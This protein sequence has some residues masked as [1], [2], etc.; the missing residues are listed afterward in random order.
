MKG[1]FEHLNL[2]VRRK[3]AESFTQTDGGDTAIRIKG[4]TDVKLSG[5]NIEGRVTRV[6]LNDTTW[7]ALERSGSTYPTGAGALSNRNAIAVQNFSGI[8]I[9]LNYDNTE[10]TTH[11]V[12]MR[13]GSERYYDITD[14]I[15]IY[16]K[17]TTGNPEIIIEEIA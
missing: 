10:A 13:N 4:E 1:V 6:T 17:A 15:T 9:R 16:A 5:L 12:V 7:T 14:D 2:W 3:L 8:E 11:G